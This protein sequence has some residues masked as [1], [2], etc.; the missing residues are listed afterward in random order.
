MTDP[1]LRKQYGL[2]L[3]D[4]I[5][6]STQLYL[7]TRGC[8]DVPICNSM[9][10]IDWHFYAMVVWSASI[11][12]GNGWLTVGI[13]VADLNGQDVLRT[14]WSDFRSFAYPFVPSSS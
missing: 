3:R 12:N 2:T 6:E 8:K 7:R 10:S 5:K 1:H 11:S 13:L 9:N 14:N 4:T